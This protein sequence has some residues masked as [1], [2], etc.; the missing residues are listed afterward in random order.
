M[1]TNNCSRGVIKENV[2]GFREASGWEGGDIK[3]DGKRGA[4]YLL[5]EASCTE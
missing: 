1:I 5:Y 4:G 2:N 3:R